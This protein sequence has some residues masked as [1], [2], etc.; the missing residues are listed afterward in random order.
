M[1]EAQEPSKTDEGQSRL[2]VG[3]ER[4]VYMPITACDKCPN[5][6]AEKYYTGDSFEDVQEWKCEK[7]GFRRIALHE[8]NDQKPEIP[9]WCPLRPNVKLTGSALLRSPS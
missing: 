4:T 1:S 5:Q 8:W 9:E 3:L 6:H 2:T 7:A